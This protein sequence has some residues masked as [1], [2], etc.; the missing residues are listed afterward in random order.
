[1]N[2]LKRIGKVIANILYVIKRWVTKDLGFNYGSL[3]SW[4]CTFGGL[5]IVF[6]FMVLVSVPWFSWKIAA[7][8]ISTNFILIFITWL[9]DKS[10]R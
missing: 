2:F 1:M 3:N 10:T 7:K 6:T 5:L 9:G 8:I 4:I